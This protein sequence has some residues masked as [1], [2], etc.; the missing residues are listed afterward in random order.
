MKKVLFVCTG[1]TC[2]SP[3]A[4]GIFNHLSKENKWDTVAESAGVA[5]FSGDEAT[6]N[7]VLALE[8]M[9]I[10][11]SSH[12]SRK[13]NIHMFDDA[14]LVVPMTNDHAVYLIQTGCPKEKIF[15]SKNEIRDPYGAG[16][17]T[18]KKTADDILNLC[19]EVNEKL[20][21]N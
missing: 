2:R 15:L 18:Y 7:A 20:N 14:D 3:M 4:E 11:I 1:N 21:D 6:K 17:D 19:N 8:E 5:A 16:I 12:R 9:G 13:T 10:D